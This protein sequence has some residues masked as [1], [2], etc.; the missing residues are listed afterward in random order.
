MIPAVRKIATSVSTSLSNCWPVASL[1]PVPGGRSGVSQIA[2]HVIPTALTTSHRIRMRQ[3][4]PSRVT[5]SRHVQEAVHVTEGL[6]RAAEPV[7]EAGRTRHE[8]LPA[9]APGARR[10]EGE[11]DRV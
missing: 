11:G 4:C 7:E 9:V 3:P 10:P 6:H 8:A 2:A 1:L 5:S